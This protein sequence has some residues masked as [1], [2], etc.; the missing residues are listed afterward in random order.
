MVVIPSMKTGKNFPPVACSRELTSFAKIFGDAAGAVGTSDAL[1]PS[2]GK[3]IPGRTGL[4]KD[5]N[6]SA[7]KGS[8][9]SVSVVAAGLAV[10]F[11]LELLMQ[12]SIIKPKWY[13]Q[14]S[15]PSANMG[16]AI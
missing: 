13:P 5:S 14:Q 4:A 7:S 1:F 2:D 9:S 6:V 11:A 10:A 15:Y 16:Q 8:E 12:S 3:V